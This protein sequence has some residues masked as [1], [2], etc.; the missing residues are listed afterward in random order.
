MHGIWKKNDVNIIKLFKCG[1]KEKGRVL[2]TEEILRGLT[3]VMQEKLGGQ[4]QSAQKQCANSIL[5][6]NTGKY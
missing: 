2:A 1:L 6:A 5:T 3:V 4:N